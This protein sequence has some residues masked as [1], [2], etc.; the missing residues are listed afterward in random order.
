MGYTTEQTKQ[1]W[2][3]VSS[4]GVLDGAAP[5]SFEGSSTFSS[6]QTSDL[7]DI[8]DTGYVDRQ[9]AMDFTDKYDK[10]ANKAGFLSDRLGTVLDTNSPYI[11]RARTKANEQSA[12]RG[13]LNSSMAAGAAEGAAI[14]RGLEVAQGDVDVDKFNVGEANRFQENRYQQA[15]ELAGQTQGF[16]NQLGGAE[17]GH[18]MDKGLADQAQEDKKEVMGI[19]QAN[20]LEE[21]QTKFGFDMDAIDVEQ[22]NTLIQMEEQYGHDKDMLDEKQADFA[23]NAENVYNRDLALQVSAH[24]Q[25]MESDMLA[26]TNN[27]T[28]EMLKQESGLYAAY[29]NAYSA[30]SSADISDKDAQLEALAKQIDGALSTAQDYKNITITGAPNFGITGI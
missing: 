25:A 23:R 13:L 12:S 6:N 19:E 27:R 2:D 10:D 9:A 11:Q 22:A 30:I 7:Q 8:R 4:G 17:A 3:D 18:I 16:L 15:G 5:N 28:M 21:M 24:G 29:L 14:D 1:Y 26:F 20:K